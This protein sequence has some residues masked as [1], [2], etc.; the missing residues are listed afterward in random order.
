MNKEH[1]VKS[2]E[3]EFQLLKS[4]VLEMAARVEDQLKSAVEVIETR[5]EILG[6]KLISE[7]VEIN[8]LQTQI[9]RLTVKIL[10]TRQPMASDLR[11]IVSVLKIVGELERIADYAKSMG[12]LIH[13]LNSVDLSEL[14][15]SIKNMLLLCISMFSE[16]VTAYRNLDPEAAVAVWKRDDEI[17]ALYQS[18]LSQLQHFMTQSPDSVQISTGLLFMGRNCE[19]IGDHLTN[20]VENIFFIATGE[21]LLKITR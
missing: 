10:A 21:D 6:K 17:D 7:D 19:R 16:S 15:G 8:A 12:K 5:N 18:F 3:E 13:Y 9:D 14:I 2:Y 20:V 1:S 11:M 4:M